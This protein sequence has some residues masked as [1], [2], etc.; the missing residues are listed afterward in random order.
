MKQENYLFSNCS[1]PIDWFS[2]WIIRVRIASSITTV[3]FSIRYLDFIERFSFQPNKSIWENGA[4]VF[5]VFFLLFC[6]C[7]HFRWYPI[8]VIIPFSSHSFQEITWYL[9]FYQIGNT[10]KD[11]QK[12]DDCFRQEL[13]LIVVLY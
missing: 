13:Y 10:K 2:F 12:W 9:Y 1:E 5:F 6:C 8:F 4:K 3:I 11:E 7:C